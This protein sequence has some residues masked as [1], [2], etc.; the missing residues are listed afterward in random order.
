[1]IVENGERVGPGLNPDSNI[2]PKTCAGQKA[3]GSIVVV[4]VDGRNYPYSNN[5]SDYELATIMLS[6]GC[7]TVINFDG[8]GSTTYLAKHEGEEEL[9][10]VNRP[11][12]SSITPRSPPTTWSTPPAPPCSSPPR[13]PTPPAWLLTFPKTASSS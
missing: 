7:V 12:A 1:M 9:T 10:L 11:S 4:T 6:L 2:A 3:D 13:A 8:G 5:V